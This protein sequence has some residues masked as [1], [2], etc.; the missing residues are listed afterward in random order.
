MR[1]HYLDTIIEVSDE[2]IVGEYT[3]LQWGPY[4]KIVRTSELSVVNNG[5]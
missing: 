1:F 5:E 3:F 4:Q 2:D